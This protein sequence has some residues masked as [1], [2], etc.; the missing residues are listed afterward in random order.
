M[1]YRGLTK[2]NTAHGRAERDGL[3]LE[4]AYN[5]KPLI[6]ERAVKRLRKEILGKGNTTGSGPFKIA[7]QSLVGGEI[8]GN[9]PVKPYGTLFF[10]YGGQGSLS[11]S[12]WLESDFANNLRSS[13]VAL[14]SN[15]LKRAAFNLNS[16]IPDGT[17]G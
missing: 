6:V 17:L 7:D 2:T 10:E 5:T 16:V 8:L 13:R 1:E 9:P 14:P 11:T 15:C 4:K 12:S 3:I